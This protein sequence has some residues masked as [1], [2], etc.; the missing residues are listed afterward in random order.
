[1]LLASSSEESLEDNAPGDQF[2][3]L[4]AGVSRWDYSDD[5]TE[6]ALVRR[7]RAPKEAP[8][9]Y[10]FTRYWNKFKHWKDDHHIFFAKVIRAHDLHRCSPGPA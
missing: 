8:S 7:K 1:M 4:V 9:V 10:F 5:D 2:V 6:Y 3:P